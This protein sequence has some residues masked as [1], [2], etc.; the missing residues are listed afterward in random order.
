MLLQLD[1]ILGQES[2]YRRNFMNSLPGPRTAHLI[3]TKGHRG[4]ENIGVFNTI[5]HLQASP[6]MLG[7]ILRPLTVARETYHNILANKHYSINT[8]AP[9]FLAAAHQCSAN[10]PVG[11]SEFAATG[12]SPHYTNTLKAPYVAEALIKIGLEYVESHQIA[13]GT[14]LVVGRVLE[15]ILPEEVV[16]QEGHIDHQKL[17]T[18][19][20]AG[21]E[22]YY[23]LQDGARK[24]YAKATKN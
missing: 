17:D 1:D 5:V 14:L 11:Q 7:F 22:Q 18:M 3:A 6:P 13:G 2:H 4:N 20:V 21:L 16:G 19:V 8:V 15:V 23:R 10:Y 12:L 24:G 9:T